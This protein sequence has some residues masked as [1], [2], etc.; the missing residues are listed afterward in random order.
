MLDAQT[1]KEDLK[2]L[3]LCI[4]PFILNAI[5]AIFS[6]TEVQVKSS[7]LSWCDIMILI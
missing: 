4:L 1:E 6:Q 5:V 2:Y 7:T 3:G